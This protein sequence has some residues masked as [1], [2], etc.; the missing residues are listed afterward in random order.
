MPKAIERYTKRRVFLTKSTTN[1]REAIQSAREIGLESNG[2]MKAF[3]RAHTALNGAR[4]N[5]RITHFRALKKIIIRLEM[6]NKAKFT[7]N[8]KIFIE[9]ATRLVELGAPIKEQHVLFALKV[10]E[11]H[12]PVLAEKTLKSMTQRGFKDRLYTNGNKIAKKSTRSTRR[13]EI[14]GRKEQEIHRKE[15][16]R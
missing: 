9:R 13:K 6:I 14:R 10:L 15:T 7:R 3:R 11:K 5:E 1:A 16:F 12:S 4:N 8:E 2:L